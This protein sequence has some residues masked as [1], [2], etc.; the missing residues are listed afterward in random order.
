[1]HRYWVWCLALGVTL[2]VSGV[3]AARLVVSIEPLAMLAEPLLGPEDQL[4]VV[5]PANR[6]PHHYALRASDLRAL[7]SADLV[8]WVGPILEPFLEKPLR[9]HPAAQPVM[10]LPGLQWPHQ[11]AHSDHAHGDR[12]PHL[13]LNPDN[14]VLII[15]WLAAQ[16]MLAAPDQAAA[17]AV[18]RDQTLARLSALTER[19]AQQLSPLGEMAFIAHHPAY[20]HFNQRFGLRQLAWVALTPEQKP[21]ARHLMALQQQAAGAKCLVTES[22]YDSHSSQQ[23]A[24]QLGLRQVVLDPMGA[25]VGPAP[26]RYERLLEQLASGLQDCLAPA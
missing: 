18:R 12:D 22:F 15:R 16:L 26:Q 10:Q 6:S 9:Q 5:L 20:G 24:R 7:Q 21:G 23:L 13:W 4:Q 11:D 3:Q 25:G 1:M 2:G 14:A 17:I 19:L 8:L